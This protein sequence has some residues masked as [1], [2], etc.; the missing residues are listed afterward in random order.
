M[1]N[2]VKED[3][4]RRIQESNKAYNEYQKEKDKISK[5]QLKEHYIQEIIK[6]IKA[7]D[8]TKVESIIKEALLCK[9]DFTYY[10]NTELDYEYRYHKNKTILE[11][12]VNQAIFTKFS[13][14]LFVSSIV[15][16]L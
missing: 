4:E 13:C 14:S 15:F 1:S 10:L 9:I 8:A 6:S 12:A 2:F 5:E 7:K 3:E 16:V 11:T